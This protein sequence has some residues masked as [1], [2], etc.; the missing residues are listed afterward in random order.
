MEQSW[1]PFAR[2]GA[3]FRTVNASHKSQRAVSNLIPRGTVDVPLSR[4]WSR[5]NLVHGSPSG[6]PP[7]P[8][9]LMKKFKRGSEVT[10]GCIQGYTLSR[11]FSTIDSPT[12]VF[13]LPPLRYVPVLTRRSDLMIIHKVR[14]YGNLCFHETAESASDW[15][16]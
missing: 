8:L 3:K 1:R 7:S 11:I 9:L 15:S 4:C 5:L 14:K 6:L 16:L 13:E 10:T 12:F 2:C